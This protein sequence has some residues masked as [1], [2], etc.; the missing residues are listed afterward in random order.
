MTK[1]EKKAFETACEDIAA[2]LNTS[3][4]KVSYM[5]SSWSF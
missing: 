2:E 1:E 4:K 5:L 3:A